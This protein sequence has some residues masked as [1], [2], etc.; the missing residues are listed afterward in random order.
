[1]LTPFK[2][3]K[4]L[5]NLLN[6]LLFNKNGDKIVLFLKPGEVLAFLFKNIN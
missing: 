3:F 4:P 5:F 6:F 1:M 2:F